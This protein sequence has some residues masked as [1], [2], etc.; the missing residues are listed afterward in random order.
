VVFT[1]LAIEELSGTD[2]DLPLLEIATWTILLSVILHGISAHPLARAY[3]GSIR[4]GDPTAPELVEVAEPHA[5]RHLLRRGVA[6]DQTAAG[7]GGSSPAE[8]ED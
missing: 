8:A 5:R 2:V 4:A 1:L 3:G 6:P 7:G